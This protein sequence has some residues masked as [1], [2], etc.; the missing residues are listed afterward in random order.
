[1]ARSHGVDIAAG[2]AQGKHVEIKASLVDQVLEEEIKA[3]RS[4]IRTRSLKNSR[5]L[6]AENTLLE[7]AN[8][9]VAGIVSIIRSYFFRRG[10]GTV[11]FVVVEVMKLARFLNR[12]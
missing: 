8:S 10:K 4:R 6:R 5:C 11:A 12:C 2:A 1:M 9:I 3:V 7:G